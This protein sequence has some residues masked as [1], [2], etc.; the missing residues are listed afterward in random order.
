MMAMQTREQDPDLTYLCLRTALDCFQKPWGELDEAQQAVVQTRARRAR[1]IGARVLASPEALGVHVPRET[2]AH[3]L[4]EIRGRYPDAA[5][6]VRDLQAQGFDEPAFRRALERDL[7]LEAVLERVAHRAAPVTE[8]EVELFYHLHLERFQRPET[9]S[10]RQ[11]LVTVNPDYPENTPEAAR[12]RLGDMAR[13][14]RRG[15]ARFEELAARHSE[16]PSALHGGLLGSVPRG[17][18]F[19]ELDQALFAM[20]PGGI[21]PVL[22]TEVGLHLLRCDQVIPAGTVPLEQVR[23]RI[24]AQLEKRRRKACQR[25][26]LEALQAA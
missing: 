21:S 3:A 12:R 5:A 15:E 17:T 2:L 23:D 4:A 16:C 24:R 1:A 20:Q 26:W 13:A 19:P 6:F 14:L 22:E 18:L 10:V 25:A 8:V 7:H 9:R 11:I